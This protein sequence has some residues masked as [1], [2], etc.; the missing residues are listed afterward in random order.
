VCAITGSPDVHL[1]GACAGGVTAS[2]LAGYLA[3]TGDRRL[4]SLTL[5]V[6][7]LDTSAETMA[8]LFLSRWSAAG[9]TKGSQRSGILAGRQ[10]SRMFAWMRP[11]DLVW[12]YWVNN[13][14]LGND[15]PA[16]DI[17]AWN[18]DMPNMTAGLHADFADLFL[19]NPLVEP[20]GLEVLGTPI[21]LA[22]VDQDAYLVAALTDHITPWQACHRTAGMLGGKTRFVLSSSGHIQAIVNPPDNPKASYRA[23]D[24][25]AA[26]PEAFLAQ[27]EKFTGSWWGEWTEWLAARGG[28]QQPAPA[29]LGTP[30]R[31]IL[32]SA[33]GDYVKS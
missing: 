4:N 33:P 17:L 28:S 14:L 12:N 20:G 29:A 1:V 25:P 16:F 2:A 24:Q 23:A 7:V 15:P 6:T 13:Y 31:P 22:K 10:L 18:A 27:A 3:A 5:L 9:A 21:D 26:S 8:S 32:G 19:E 11:N 30:D